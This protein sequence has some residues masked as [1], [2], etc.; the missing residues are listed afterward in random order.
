MGGKWA[1]THLQQALLNDLGQAG[2]H[3]LGPQLQGRRRQQV[4]QAH[5]R[6][7]HHLRTPRLDPGTWKENKGLVS[8]MYACLACGNGR[9][10]HLPH[11]PMSRC[12]KKL[13][14]LHA[15][16]SSPIPA[17]SLGMAGSRLLLSAVH[18]SSIRHA[19]QG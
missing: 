5:Q 16:P 4:L 9:M 2:L 15:G 7:P 18:A 13:S 19:V 1:R 12:R 3:P 14:N 6:H 17:V 11:C 10:H 8:E